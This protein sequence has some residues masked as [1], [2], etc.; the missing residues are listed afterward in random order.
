MF[1]MTC[2]WCR[3]RAVVPRG[4]AHEQSIAEA[5]GCVPAASFDLT[6]A[7]A[8]VVVSCAPPFDGA[9][10]IRVRE[11]THHVG[12]ARRAAPLTPGARAARARAQAQRGCGR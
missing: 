12:F 9:A 4:S 1:V 10:E 8:Q 7:C 2:T 6:A 3:A 11:S 5:E